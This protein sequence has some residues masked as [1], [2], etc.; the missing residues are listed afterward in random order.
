MHKLL[1]LTACLAV[2]A[3]CSTPKPPPTAPTTS[4]QEGTTADV[5]YPRVDYSQ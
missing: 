1:L 4:T 5:F 2:L 3:G